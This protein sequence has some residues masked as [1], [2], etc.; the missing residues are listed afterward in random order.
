MTLA[1][2][3][4]K[5]RFLKSMKWFLHNM[6]FCTTL[7]AESGRIKIYKFSK[8]NFTNIMFSYLILLSFNRE[9]K[10]SKKI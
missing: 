1:I 3:L 7:K 5:P 10:Q 4:G 6:F 2:A 9:W 8:L